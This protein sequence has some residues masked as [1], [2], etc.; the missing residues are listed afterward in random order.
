[1]SV[2]KMIEL[3]VTYELDETT[4]T[5]LYQM[6]C[7][8]LITRSNWEKFY[9]TCADWQF[10]FDGNDIEDKDGKIIYTRDRNGFMVK[11]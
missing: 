9:E 11:R 4:W 7:H 10:S 2:K 8:G 3:Y 5:M 1:M 6:T